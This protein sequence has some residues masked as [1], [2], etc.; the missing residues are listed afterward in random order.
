MK[1]GYS[2]TYFANQWARQRRIQAELMG[3][4]NKK[5]LQLQVEDLIEHEEDLREC[6][7]KMDNL[8]R[9]QHRTAAENRT[10]ASLPGHIAFLE[11]EVDRILLE[12]GGDNF[13]HIPEADGEKLF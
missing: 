6:N 8:R 3:D 10:L 1:R 7:D 2:H 4:T 13:R 9:R 5:Q 11:E 12:L